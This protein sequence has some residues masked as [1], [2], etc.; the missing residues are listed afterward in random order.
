MTNLKNKLTV[1][2]TTHILPSA[3]KVDVIEATIASIRKNFKSISDCKFLIYCDSKVNNRN[4]KDYINN[5]YKIQNVEVIDVPHE[6]FAYSGLQNNYINSIKRSKTPFVFCCEHD[7][8]FLR[9]IDTVKLIDTMHTNTFINFVRF[10]KRDN[11]KAH[12]HNPAP[13]DA[14]FWET[15]VEPE[16]LMIKQPLMKTDCI[17]THPHIIRKDKFLN[18][19]LEIASRTNYRVPGMVEFNLIR[20]YKKD[21]LHLGFNKAHRKWGVYNYGSKEELKIISHTDGSEKH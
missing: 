5:L 12:I 20:E 17:A 19:W 14:D 21:I 7:W 9:E 2:I 1:V 11:S 10:N 15:H 16:T 18:D 6:G 8:Y 4:Y 3:P 13:G